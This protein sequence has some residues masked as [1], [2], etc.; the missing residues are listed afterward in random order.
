MGSQLRSVEYNKIAWAM[1]DIDFNW[2]TNNLSR[3]HPTKGLIVKCKRYV[4]TK[5]PIKEGGVVPRHIP[6]HILP[7]LQRSKEWNDRKEIREKLPRE[8]ENATRNIGNDQ[9]KKSV[10]NIETDSDEESKK[11]EEDSKEKTDTEKDDNQEILALRMQLEEVRRPK[12][13]EISKKDAEISKKDEEISKQAA[14]LSKLKRKKQE[15]EGRGSSDLKTKLDID[16]EP[17]QKRKLSTKEERSVPGGQTT[18]AMSVSMPNKDIY[19]SDRY[20]DEKYEYR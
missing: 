12:D 8:K 19:Y 9:K 6:E 17:L 4:G 18:T 14:E 5:K 11:T 13:A 20:T 2:K 7:K 16:E 3:S 15:M 10:R 1:E